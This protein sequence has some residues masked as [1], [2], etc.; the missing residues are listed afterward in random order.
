[1]PGI[2]EG[3]HHENGMPVARL[4][5]RAQPREREPQRL[6]SQ[7]GK[8][9]LRPQQKARVADQ[10]RQPPPTLLLAPA[11]PAV[12]RPQPPCR[13]AEDQHAEPLARRVGD[14]IVEALAHRPQ[15]PKIMVLLQQPVAAWQIVGLQRLDFA[16]I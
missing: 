4:P 7:I 13:R 6:G 9:L 15:S 14:R 16:G 3:L 1:M 11:D 8:G 2:D 12:A 5:I 10:E